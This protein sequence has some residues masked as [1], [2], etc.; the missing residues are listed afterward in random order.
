MVFLYAYLDLKREI[1]L[2]VLYN[3]DEE[4][5]LDAQCFFSVRWTA[6][7]RH[8]TIITATARGF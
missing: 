3:H 2:Q 5:Q 8:S 7:V 4:W 1:F 6:D